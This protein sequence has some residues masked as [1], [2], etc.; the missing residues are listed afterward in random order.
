MH[1]HLNKKHYRMEMYE[2]PISWKSLTSDDV[3]IYDEG[4]KMSQWN[5]SKCDEEERI[6][7]GWVVPVSVILDDSFIVSILRRT[8]SN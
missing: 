5:G 2:V 3:F 8:L 4:A 6:T 7:E 1:F